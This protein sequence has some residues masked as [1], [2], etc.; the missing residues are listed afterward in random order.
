MVSRIARPID[1]DKRGLRSFVQN[2]LV[3]SVE[4]WLRGRANQDAPI[5]SAK[6]LAVERLEVTDSDGRSTHTVTVFVNSRP[7]GAKGVAIIGASA[8]RDR[9]NIYVNGALSPVDF[10]VPTK[11]SDRMSP[12]W[13]CTSETCLPYGLYAN[14]IHEVTH[15][16]DIFMK[17]I[18]YDPQDVLNRGEAAWGLY[19]NDPAEVR[20][21]MQQIVDETER[22]AG[23]IRDHAKSNQHLIGIV[24]KTST[25]W[26]LIE[27][28]L[29]L[30]NKARILKSVYEALDRQGLLLGDPGRVAARFLC[31]EPI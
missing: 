1:V 22:M 25:T 15:T 2:L 13:E 11:W 27:K 24:L 3:P 29:T 16:A 7:S 18:G 17:E 20:A 14:L 19:V 21:F 10:L 6:N 23:K 30:K 5:G 28:H 9:I 8:T 12:I 4:E 26:K 31:S